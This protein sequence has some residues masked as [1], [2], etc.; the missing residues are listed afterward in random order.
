MIYLT[1]PNHTLGSH[2]YF[3]RQWRFVSKIFILE[4][5]TEIPRVG[6]LN[7]PLVTLFPQ[8]LRSF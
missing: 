6:S 7:G 8:R 4:I 1:V 3:K 2:L 5:P